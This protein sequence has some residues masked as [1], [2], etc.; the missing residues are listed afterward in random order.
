MAARATFPFENSA[1]E[2]HAWLT[3]PM[4]VESDNRPP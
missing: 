3:G 4:P 1:E 2:V